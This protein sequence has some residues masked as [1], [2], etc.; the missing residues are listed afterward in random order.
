[1]ART[2][3]AY[4][5]RARLRALLR[6]ARNAGMPHGKPFG[7]CWQPGCTEWGVACFFPDHEWGGPGGGPRK[8]PDDCLCDKH[9]KH[10]G[11]CKGCGCFAGGIESFDFALH[12][13][14]GFCDNCAWQLSAEYEREQRTWYDDDYYDGF[15]PYAD[16]PPTIV[17]VGGWP[18]EVF[19]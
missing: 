5:E 12:G 4:K 13:Y 6:S 19:A 9:I 2:E 18:E 7:M 17:I 15:D 8:H 1:M 3:G 14:D 10:S 11:F 16:D